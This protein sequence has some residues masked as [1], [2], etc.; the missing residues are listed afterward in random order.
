[1]EKAAGQH[2]HVI[3]IP[4]N[5]RAF[6][7]EEPDFPSNGPAKN[8]AGGAGGPPGTGSPKA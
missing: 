3:G 7:I 2:E 4:V 1:M 8:A 5:N 6:G